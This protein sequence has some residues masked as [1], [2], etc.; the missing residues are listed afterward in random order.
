MAWTANITHRQRA[1][2][3]PAGDGA[4]LRV[5]ADHRLQQEEGHAA[6]KGKETVR[7]EENTCA[8]RGKHPEW[9]TVT[10][11]ERQVSRH[12]KHSAIK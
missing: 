1:E 5:L 6:K 4:L 12:S 8:H 10:A 2:F 3:G 11:L 7:Q 9:I